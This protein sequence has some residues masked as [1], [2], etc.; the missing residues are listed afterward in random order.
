MHSNAV[1]GYSASYD[2]LSKEWRI[3][4]NIEAGLNALQQ[5]VEPLERIIRLLA[6]RLDAPILQVTLA[7]KAFRYDSP[8]V[9]HFCLLKGARALSDFN[10]CIELAR[11]GYVQEIC[12][13][14]RTMV[15]CIRHLEYVVEPYGSGEHKASAERYVQEFFADG[16]RGAAADP[17]KFQMQQGKVHDALGKV[18][19]QIS[20][21][22]GKDSDGRKPA[23]ALYRD[24]YGVMSNYVHARYPECIDLYGGKPGE[25]HVR[26]MSGTPKDA[27]S[28]EILQSFSTTLAQGFVMMIQGLKLKAIVDADP[29][30]GRWYM[31]HVG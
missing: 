21:E 2:G 5:E 7:G 14:I 29:M 28:L 22:L 19:D 20:A 6:A 27:E 30:I 8:D 17:H 16:R 26:G 15:E 12:V 13:L 31:S 24:T 18:L 11:R 9:R 4:I 25:F 23:G 3:A 10:A 1:R